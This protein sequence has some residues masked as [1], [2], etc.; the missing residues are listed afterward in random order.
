[1]VGKQSIFPVA[2][3][4]GVP[5]SKV[6]SDMGDDLA[7]DVLGGVGVHV[8]SSVVGVNDTD[9]AGGERDQISKTDDVAASRA[10]DCSAV[11][12]RKVSPCLVQ[13]TLCFQRNRSR[14]FILA[15]LDFVSMSFR[16]VR[17]M[18][19]KTPEQRMRKCSIFR[20]IGNLLN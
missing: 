10:S 11:V 7:V 5:S 3:D 1:M 20:K 6:A 19:M 15:R 17:I 8:G 14:K 9:H 12:L 18:K 2:G 16:G 13:K 4:P